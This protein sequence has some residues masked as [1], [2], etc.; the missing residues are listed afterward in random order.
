MHR[1]D[2]SAMVTGDQTRHRRRPRSVIV[3][4]MTCITIAGA[5][6][7]A[8]CPGDDPQGSN[9]M[10][11]NLANMA[12]TF[13]S[14]EIFGIDPSAGAVVLVFGNFTG[15]SGPFRLEANGVGASATGEA[16]VGSL[17]LL[18]NIGN[19]RAGQ[20]PQPG[21]RSR[22]TRVLSSQMAGYRRKPGVRTSGHVGRAGPGGESSRWDRTAGHAESLDVHCVNG[23]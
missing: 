22:S 9:A 8:G 19:F 13:S 14:G 4:L 17:T 6:L 16:T 10:V 5:L 2:I 15:N 12:F 21:T 23:Q 20:G 18:V 1:R 3:Y 11:S 7:V